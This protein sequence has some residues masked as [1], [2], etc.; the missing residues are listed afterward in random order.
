MQGLLQELELLV[1]LVVVEDT[2]KVYQEVQP[3]NL[4][5]HQVVMEILVGILLL[6]L[7]EDLEVAAPG[8][9]VLL[10]IHLEVAAAGALVD[11]LI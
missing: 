2:M 6:G 5:V 7:Q 11:L 8:V 9:L 3:L 10:E 4:A 1:D